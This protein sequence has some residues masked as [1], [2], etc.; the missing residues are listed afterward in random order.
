MDVPTEQQTGSKKIRSEDRRQ[1]SDFTSVQIE[2]MFGWR[3]EIVVSGKQ[4]VEV[5]GTAPEVL[6]EVRDQTLHIQEKP[7]SSFG[8]GDGVTVHITVPQLERVTASEQSTVKVTGIRP[9]N[10]LELSAKVATSRC[11]EAPS[12]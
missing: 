12:K 4:S 6:T 5:R 10:R 1:V 2:P 3:V 9:E 7:G 11:Q 8:P